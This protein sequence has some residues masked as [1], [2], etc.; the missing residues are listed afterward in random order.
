M[1]HIAYMADY[2][3][4]NLDVRYGRFWM[5]EYNLSIPMD[6]LAAINNLSFIINILMFVLIMGHICDQNITKGS[7]VL[8]ILWA[9]EVATT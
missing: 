2:T 7:T 4:V 8:F 3:K 6:H 9:C 1:Y 5:A